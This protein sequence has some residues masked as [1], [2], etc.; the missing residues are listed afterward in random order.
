MRSLD[1]LAARLLQQ[2]AKLNIRVLGTGQVEAIRPKNLEGID[3]KL[4]PGGGYQRPKLRR[5][6][7]L[8]KLPAG[9][10]LCHLFG[11]NY[12]PTLQGVIIRLCNGHGFL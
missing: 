9:H 3:L 2:Q 6:S 4:F 10:A 5:F 11:L 7:L 12:G 8:Q 1:N